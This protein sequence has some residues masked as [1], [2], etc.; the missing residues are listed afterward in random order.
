MESLFLGLSP[1]VSVLPHLMDSSISLVYNYF[2]LLPVI[3]E[4]WELQVIL[5]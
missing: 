2:P 5:I 3:L 4:A 1:C